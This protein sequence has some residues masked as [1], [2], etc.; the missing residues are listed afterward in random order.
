MTDY[1]KNTY[2]KPVSMYRVA[3][4]IGI[5]VLLI[6]FATMFVMNRVQ[7]ARYS[8]GLRQALSILSEAM[9]FANFE[10]DYTKESDVLYYYIVDV[11]NTK[12]DSIDC[13][14]SN[15]L[16]CKAKEYRTFNNKARMSDLIYNNGSKIG[17]NNFLFLINK[18]KF[19]DDNLFITV[20]VNGGNV[21]P[22][23]LGYDVFVFQIKNSKIRAMGNKTTA[24][25]LEK[26]SF[27]CYDRSTS[28]DE[29]LGI[30]CTYNAFFEKDYFE[31]L[32]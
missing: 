23:R 17:V 9:V 12:F 20:D 30:N 6:A 31:K 28:E 3:I 8:V 24:Y 22:N 13:L 27:Y 29:L 11:F 5:F 19:T 15:E 18:P 21:K 32:W 1:F 25:P 10:S 2:Y 4:C 16:V 26:Y 7:K 14:H